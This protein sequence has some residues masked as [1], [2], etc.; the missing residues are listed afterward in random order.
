M[1]KYIFIAICFFLVGCGSKRIAIQTP[2]VRSIQH[3]GKKDTIKNIIDKNSVRSKIA[4]NQSNLLW[5]NIDYK[6]APWV[7]NVSR[8]AT[9]TEG[10]QNRHITVWASHGRYYSQEKGIWKWQRPFLFGTTEDLFTQTIVVPYL[11]PMLENAGAIV[12]TPRERDWQANEV[13]VD[14]DKTFETHSIYQEK[15]TINV[16]HDASVRGFA[17]HEGRYKDQEN[18]F[19]SGTT[20]KVKATKRDGSQ[21]VY[22]P[23]IPATGRYAVYVSYPTI[24]KS[25]SD[26]RYVVYHQGQQT[27]FRVNQQMGG[28]TWVYLGTF[29]FDKGCSIYNKVVL[30]GESVHEGFVTAD[31]VRFGGGMG[32]I[33]RGDTVS[34]MPRCL[35][36]ARYYAQ[37]AGAPYS[38]YSDKK[39]VDDYR[40]D[41]NARSFMSNW[42]SG[43]SCYVPDTIGKKVPIELSL[44]VHSDAGY[45]QDFSSLFGSLGICTTDFNNG[46][47]RTGISREASWSFANDLIR[48]LYYDISKT[49]GLQWPTR[50]VKDANYSETRC[51]E[52]PSAIIETLS[53]QNFPDMALAQDPMFKFTLARSLYKSILRFI[54]KSHGNRYV[55]APLPPINPAVEFT[56]ADKVTITWDPQPDPQE[57]SAMPDAY[58]I[59]KRLGVSGFDNG[60]LVEGNSYSLRLQ[61]GVVYSFKITA[62]NKGGESFPSQVVTALYHAGATRSIMIVNGFHRLSAPAVL[63]T[64][65]AQGFEMDI[66]PGVCYG[67]TYG[68]SGPQQCFDKHLAGREGPGTL[69]YSNQQWQGKLIAGNEMDDAYIHAEA[70]K[71]M[72]QYNVTSCSSHAVEAGKVDL[73]KYH[74]VDMLFGLQKVD[75]NRVYRYKTFTPVMQTLLDRFAQ[76]G[77]SLLVSGSYIGTDMCEPSDTAFLHQVL[78][79]KADGALRTNT[80]SMINGMGTSF[81]IYR[82][83]NSEHY[84]AT[85][86]DILTPLS[87]A[88]SA[89]SYSDGHSACVAYEGINYRAFTMG[90]PFE[91]ITSYR[92]RSAIMKGIINFLVEKSITK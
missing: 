75:G 8:K 78:K 16:W 11:I 27:E 71:S 86:V 31:A 22:Q 62:V 9:I 12:F 14:N 37:W 79:V 42:L 60:E 66:D 83:L 26:A 68:W 1:R 67:K 65:S 10:L 28:G 38:V 17:F 21:I 3:D 46:K 33:E 13:I 77:G 29:D 7:F 32:N 87:P 50:G 88:F 59:Y 84:A 91:C 18:P 20:R 2:T 74:L 80:D 64:S 56:G 58:I 47:Y 19:E 63:N 69:G 45:Q 72:L 36:G 23:D 54:A 70:M 55:I 24:N 48:G 5:R 89:M 40:D 81:D 76:S 82:K 85:L 43:G 30:Y 51:P 35:E 57:K 41:I 15:N 52:V 90:F 6:G 34:G 61:P 39:G 73:M 49:F 92:K 25:V 4:T 53:H 44:A